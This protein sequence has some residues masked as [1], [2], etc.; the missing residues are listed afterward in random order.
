MRVG[1]KTPNGAASIIIPI[2]PEGTQ[3]NIPGVGPYYNSHGGRIVN[4]LMT[5]QI[6]GLEDI[7]LP[8]YSEVDPSMRGTMSVDLTTAEGGTVTIK[9][10][11][12]NVLSTIGLNDPSFQERMNTHGIRLR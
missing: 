8:Y 6:E 7:D 12:G 11:D 5:Y 10:L 1:V 9:D 2:G 3:L 4:E